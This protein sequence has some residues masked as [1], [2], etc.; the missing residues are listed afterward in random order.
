MNNQSLITGLQSVTYSSAQLNESQRFFSDC[1]LISINDRA[2]ELANGSRIYVTEKTD[3]EHE[4]GAIEW[5]IKDAAALEI[6]KLRLIHLGLSITEV[7]EGLSVIDPQ[8][9]KVTFSINSLTEPQ[10]VSTNTNSYNRKLRIDTAVPV[11]RPVQPIAIGHIVLFTDCLDQTEAFYKTLGFVESDRFI[12]RCVFLRCGIN[13]NHHDLLLITAPSNQAGLNH[14]AFEM[15]DIYDVFSTGI[16]LDACG[17]KTRLGPGRHPIS[18]ATFWYFECP[19]GAAIEFTA[20]SDFLTENW[21]P[22]SMVPDPKTVTEW[23]IDGGINSTTRR[24][25]GAVL[26]GTF[27]DEYKFKK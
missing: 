1:G 7:A 22:R 3:K 12:D 18:S 5:A 15:R 8:G 13:G 9:M 21:S 4:L 14:V 11:A 2:W 25:H 16:A 6:V 23:A 24:Q 17:W 26:R 19:S 20:D 27:V 10:D